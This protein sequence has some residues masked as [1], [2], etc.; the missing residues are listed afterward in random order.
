MSEPAREHYVYALY[1]WDGSPFYIGMGKSDRWLQHERERSSTNRHKQATI[2][3][4]IAIGGYVPK[5]KLADNLTRAEAAEHE[6]YLIAAIGRRPAGPLVNWTAGG[7]GTADPSPELRQKRIESNRR[8]RLSAET[9]RKIGDASRAR[10][11]GANHPRYGCIVSAET[12]EKIGA[13][14]R[15]KPGPKGH[16]ASATARAKMSAA[17]KA[18]N[19]S[20]ES[21][22]SRRPD[23]I[24]KIRAKAVAK[25]VAQRSS[26]QP[27]Q[28]AAR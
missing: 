23:V 14:N 13:A 18:R 11:Q 8:R 27:Q 21:N 26:N 28:R 15:G 17:A 1:R 9:R 12:R 2:D 20:G 5:Q 10:N 16:R 6:Q 25:W 3:A 24:E 19:I 7:E 4:V 22:P